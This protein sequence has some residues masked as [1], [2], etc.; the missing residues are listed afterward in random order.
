MTQAATLAIFGG[1]F[2]PIHLGHTIV[3]E[4][5]RVKLGLEKVVFVPAGQP[6]LKSDRPVS[7]ARHRLEMV[8]LG[9][10]DNPHFKVSAVEVNRPGPSYAVDTVEAMRRESGGDAKLAF[11]LGSDALA[12]LAQWKQPQRLIHL[13]QLVAFGRP[14]LPLPPLGSLDTAVPGL[15]KHVTV[16]EV[17]QVDISASEIRRRV[18]SGLP[19]SGMVPEPVERYILEQGLYRGG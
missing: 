10:L 19:I 12:E 9:V 17:P 8:R 3:A 1:T 5:V 11:I 18:A 14:G 15:S 6:W 7:D 2:D 13:C 16:V 4:E